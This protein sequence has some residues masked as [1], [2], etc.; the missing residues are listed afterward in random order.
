M[1]SKHIVLFTMNASIF[2]VIGICLFYL[3]PISPQ[4]KL[5]LKFYLLKLNILNIFSKEIL[6]MDR[7]G[8]GVIFKLNMFQY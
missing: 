2:S 1:H 5:F 8:G 4:N 7:N 6:V 3:T